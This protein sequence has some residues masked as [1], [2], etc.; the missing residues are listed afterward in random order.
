MDGVT[1]AQAQEMMQALNFTSSPIFWVMMATSIVSLILWIM[2]LIKIFQHAGVG[3]GILGIFCSIY[4]FIWGWLNAK[5]YEF[6]PV[7][8]LW[9]FLIV[10]QVIQWVLLQGV[11]VQRFGSIM[12]IM[13]TPMPG[14]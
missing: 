3:L 11:M 10:L 14:Y 1:D 6:T 13:G 8:L 4:T 12:D 5:Q 7:M 2:V 9:T